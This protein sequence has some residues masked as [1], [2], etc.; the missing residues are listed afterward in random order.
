MAITTVKTV[1][2]IPQYDI[3]GDIKKIS[4]YDFA[5]ENSKIIPI[6]TI[7]FM[8]QG[9]NVLFPG[10]GLREVLISLPYKEMEEV[11]DIINQINS[12]IFRYTG[13][14]TR[15]YIDENNPAN[16]F[17]KGNIVLRIDIEGILAPLTIGVDKSRTFYVKHPSVFMSNNQGVKNGN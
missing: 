6:I 4:E 11:Y 17:I 8:E 9:S 16:D 5:T 2:F 3:L 10:M 14:T 12:H 13:Y 7:L 1:D 15:T